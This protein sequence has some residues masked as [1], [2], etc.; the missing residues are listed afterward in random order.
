M[1]SKQGEI[2]KIKLIA[3]DPP[4]VYFQLGEEHCL[5]ARHALT[6]FAEAAPGSNVVVFG[7]KNNRGQF[8]ADQYRVLEKNQLWLD[9]S[10]SRYPRKK[11]SQP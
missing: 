6:F 3:S 1:L 8:I 2:Q 5:I 10:L 11:A 7:H 9:F 4:L